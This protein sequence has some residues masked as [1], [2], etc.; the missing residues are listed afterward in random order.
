MVDGTCPPDVQYCHERCIAQQDGQNDQQLDDVHEVVPHSQ[1]GCQGDQGVLG[2][3]LALLL[4]ILHGFQVCLQKKKKIAGSFFHPGLAAQ[5]QPSAAKPSEDQNKICTA[6]LVSESLYRNV[7]CKHTCTDYHTRNYFCE[8][9]VAFLEAY[10]LSPGWSQTLIAPA[11]PASAGQF[12]R[13]EI[14]HS[15]LTALLAL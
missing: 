15:L 6:S 5:S 8:I 12:C 3:N 4:S 13:F 10:K 9:T 1:A 14:M 7:A 11:A 2:I